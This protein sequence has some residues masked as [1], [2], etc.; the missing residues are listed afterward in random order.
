[1]ILLAGYGYVGKAIH[2]TFKDVVDIYVV[3]P[4]HNKNKMSDFNPEKVIIAV[5]TPEGKNGECDM[6]NVFDVLKKVAPAVPVLIKSTISIEG[7]HTLK[8]KFPDHRVTF[9]P[10]F[11]RAKTATQDFQTTKHIY[12]AGQ[13][14]HGWIPFFKKIF[15]TAQYSVRKTPEELIAGK[16]FRNAFLAT[17]VTFFNQLYDFCEKY[18][19]KW[20]QVR[21]VVTDDIRIG[22]DHT[23]V[24]E[25]RGFGGHCLPKDTKALIKSASKAKLNLSLIEEVL[26]YNDDIKKL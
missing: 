6:T 13:W 14:G 26:K 12:L 4:K 8:K 1:M 2:E 23:D 19:L 24:T 5:S 9:S 21:E 20:E 11:L 10:E 22:R 15:P 17:K 18:D 16:Y 3:D 25:E 7:W